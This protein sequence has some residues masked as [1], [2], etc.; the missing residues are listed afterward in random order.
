MATYAAQAVLIMA[1]MGIPTMRYETLD[2]SPMGGRDGFGTWSCTS[3][4]DTSKWRAKPEVAVVGN[5]LRALRDPGPNYVVPKIGVRIAGNVERRFTGKRTGAVTAWLWVTG[6]SPVQAAVT[7]SQG[8]RT[9][10]VTKRLTQVPLRLSLL[11]QA[12]LRRAGGALRCGRRWRAVLAHPTRQ[13]CGHERRPPPNRRRAPSIR[14]GS[15]VRG[16]SSTHRRAADPIPKVCTT[17]VGVKGAE[18][19][20]AMACGHPD[21]DHRRATRS[22]RVGGTPLPANARR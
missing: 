19:R 8:T 1:G 16:R 2:D 21:P 4:T 22:Y 3:S 6:N 18:R 7:D 12:R 20:C 14:A 17:S 10:Q 11:V 5:L 13:E 9:F 15:P